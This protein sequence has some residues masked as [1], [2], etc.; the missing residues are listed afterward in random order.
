L[1]KCHPNAACTINGGS[2]ACTC[3]PGYVGDGINKCDAFRV[4]FDVDECA[5]NTH[6]CHVDAICSNAFGSF[7]CTCKSGM[8]GNGTDCKDID[9]CHLY[10]R[11]GVLY[12]VCHEGSTCVNT[13]GS[14]I[15]KNC[16]HGYNERDG[17]NDIDEC[18][19]DGLNKCSEFSQCTNLKGSYTCKCSN[20]Y[21]DESVARHAGEVCTEINECENQTNSFSPDKQL[22]LQAESKT[23]N[24]LTFLY[25]GARD[26][27]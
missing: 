16:P 22:K 17:C 10:T 19:N 7:T 4:I 8:F 23:Q 1:G 9:E 26:T 21:R 18:S 3:N 13:L 2:Y 15:C 11:P 25:I 5:E 14:Y 12:E 6:N 24:D 20:G 27:W